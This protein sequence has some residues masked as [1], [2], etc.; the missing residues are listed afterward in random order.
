[1]REGWKVGAVALVFLASTAD[2]R[3]ASTSA[4]R[5]SRD[6]ESPGGV[7]LSSSTTVSDRDDE[8]AG[9]S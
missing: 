6:E 2:V 5:D 8:V 9:V 4:D 3:P 7:A 1:M